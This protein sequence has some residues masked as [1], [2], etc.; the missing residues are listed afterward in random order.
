MEKINQLIVNTAKSYIGQ[1]EK[2]GNT[3][4]V[5]PE[6]EKSMI[7][8]GFKPGYSWCA[9]FGEKVWMEAYNNY[10]KNISIA[11]TSIFSVG[12][13]DTLNRFKKSNLFIFTT[14]QPIPG[15]LVFW[16]K[17]KDGVAGWQGHVG[18]FLQMSNGKMI[19][20][21]G[22]TNN[23]GSRDGDGVYQKEREID[24]YNNNGLRLVGFINPKL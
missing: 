19:T 22:N 4:F 11:L 13:I 14:T 16:Q 3:G 15:A 20:I 23:K 10:N 7:S 9:L 5:D 18:I 24:L 6:F 8:F 12:A 21:D 1:R 17:Y 2:P